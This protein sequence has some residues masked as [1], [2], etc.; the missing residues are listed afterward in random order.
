M[1]L[2]QVASNIAERLKTGTA[3]SEFADKIKT[4]DFENVVQ[5]IANKCNV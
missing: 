3:A 1:G 5:K 2:L 4:A